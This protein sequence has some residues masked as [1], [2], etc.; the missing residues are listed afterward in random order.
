[1]SAA[2]GALAASPR[3]AGA[4]RYYRT[5]SVVAAPAT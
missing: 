3:S 5:Q 2:S 1:M 4:L